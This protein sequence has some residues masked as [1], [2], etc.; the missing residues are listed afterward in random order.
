MAPTSQLR[1]KLLGGFEVRQ[2]GGPVVAISGKKTRAL[3]AYLALMPGR[4]HGREKLADLLW[5]DR[6]DKQ[7]RD[8]LRQA[9]TELRDVLSPLSPALLS[10]EQ[11]RLSVDPGA[12]EVDALQFEALAAGEDRD[13]LRRGI[14]L[15]GGDL[16]DGLAVHDPT[17]EDWLRGERQ[18]YRELAVAVLKKLATCETGAAAITAAQR[19]LALD[20]LHE[21]GYRA[22]MRLHAEA[23]DLAAGLRQ[24]EICRALLKRELDILPSLETEELHRRIKDRSQRQSNGNNAAAFSEQ[25]RAPASKASVAVLPFRNLSG[26]T[27]QQYFSDG[28]S[29]DIIT[30]LSRFRD[31]LVIPRNSAF[32]FRDSQED[33][34]EIGRDLKVAYLVEGS[35]R[36]SASRIRITARLIEVETGAQIWSEHYDRE[37]AEIFALQDQLVQAIVA[38][39]PGRILESGA[40]SARRKRPE[41][42]AAYDFYL[43]GLEL[44]FSFADANTL[45]ARA[46]FEKAITLD[47]TMAPAYAWLGGT[48]LREWWAHR[49]V[50]ALER[51]YAL[52]KKA[53]AA[54]SNDGMCHGALGY[55]CMERRQFD[56]AA[57][58]IDRYLKLNPNDPTASADQAALAAY[59]GRAEEAISWME[60]AFRLDPFAPPWYNSMHGMIFFAAARY[61][62]AIAA[63]RRVIE[64]RDHNWDSLYVIASLG[65][66]GRADEA[67]AIAAER[68]VSLTH[69]FLSK[70]AAGEPY[71]NPADLERLLEGLRK[72][73]L[74]E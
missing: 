58:H 72:A 13:A 10:T 47:P 22:L 61:A 41:N 44:Q 69:S 27:E 71:K 35:V 33:A 53:V 7:A 15:Y 19:L 68:A 32:Q 49:S 6:G 63:F 30:E 67:R 45:A 12:M 73:A 60:N 59:V 25:P 39:L 8:S 26:D 28:L 17:F 51:A 48:Y 52:S 55:V 18:R 56:D 5:S 1:V 23:G 16:L 34:K 24:Y 70:L 29:E 54:D 64:W 43:R 62:E 14:A 11:D 21:E 9:L 38:A 3:M 46:M 37:L 65:H 20:P 36:R 50:E 31:L 40:R 66:L 57:F 74:P 42:L 4:T 2:A